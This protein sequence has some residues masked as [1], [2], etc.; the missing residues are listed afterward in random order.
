MLGLAF[1]RLFEVIMVV[2]PSGLRACAAMLIS[3]V[4]LCAGLGCHK[5][6]SSSTSTSTTLTVTGKVTFT[7]IPIHRD[8]AGVPTGLETDSSTFVTTYI[9]RGLALRFFQLRPQVNPDYTTTYVWTQVAA[10]TTDTDGKYTA[11]VPKDYETFAEISAQITEPVSPSS[12]VNIV[13]DPQGVYSQK[14]ITD[15]TTYVI[16]KALDGTVSTTDAVHS[17][18]ATADTT[19]DWAVGLNDPWLVVPPKWWSPAKSTFTYPETVAAG[20]RILGILDSC[21]EFATT[22]GNVVPASSAA[23]LDLHYRP[24]LTTRRGTFIEFNAQAFP[25]AF[26]GLSFHYLGSVSAGGTVD[27]VAQGDD[28]FD[29]GVLYPL[30][31]RATI[32]GQRKTNIIPT[33][34]PATSLAPDLALIE[35]FGDVMAAALQKHP[36]LPAGPSGNRYGTLRDIR[37]LS[38]LPASQ[39]GPFSAPA[40]SALTWELILHAQGLPTPGTKTDWDKIAALDMYR[41]YV[42]L[43]PTT[44]VGTATVVVDTVSIYTQLA[45]LQESKAS[46]D[47]LDLKTLFTDAYLVP[48]CARFNIP[49]T[50]AADAILPKYTTNWGIDPNTLFS[51]LPTATFTMSGA[52]KIKRYY[53]DDNGLEQ[54]VD[55][56]PNNSHGEVA[57]TLFAMSLDATYNLKAKTVPDLP[58]GAAIEL[59]LDGNLLEPKLFTPGGATSFPLTLKGSADLTTPTYHSFR[60]RMLSPT[61]LVSDTQVTVQLEK[62]N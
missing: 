38:A 1:V 36:Y 11:T 57:Y 3:A 53:L 2:R 62:T 12:T 32:Y 45:R 14:L 18:M 44:T 42:G 7:R 21:Y 59:V 47:A 35:G 50:T 24:G 60:I 55:Y 13:S 40:I 28:A 51:P 37:D 27:G 52:T 56:Y 41:L 25:K 29:T 58:A 22:F 54:S 9:S 10:A 30:L 43:N 39:I 61:T 4:V 20:S 19:L 6:S 17:S 5:S 8:A 49:W 23:T 31:G 48:I 15:R 46:T 33:G 16:R 34:Y 26:D